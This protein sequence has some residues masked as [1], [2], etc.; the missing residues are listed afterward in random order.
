MNPP[1]SVMANVSGR[2]ADAAYRH[3]ASALAWLAPGGRL[4]TI[5]GANFSPKLPA[6]LDSFL[7]LQERGHVVFTAAIAGSVYAKHG[8]TIDTRLTVIDKAPAEPEAYVSIRAAI[9]VLTS[10]RRP[11]PGRR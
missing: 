2:V 5:T 3:I 9:I 8:T 1:F 4:V 6:W 10:I 7:R 11:R